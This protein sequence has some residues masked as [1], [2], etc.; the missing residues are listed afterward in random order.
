MRRTRIGAVLLVGAVGLCLGASIP[1]WL[2]DAI[3][4]WN[5]ENP[6]VS[7]RFVDI[8]DEFVWYM[9]PENE[10]F[11]QREIRARIHTI[12]QEHGY[13][14]TDEEELVTTGKPPSPVS[15]HIPKKCWRRSY[16]LDIQALSDTKSSRGGR[17]SQRQR[18]LTSMVCEDEGSW[19]L[20][21]RILQ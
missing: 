12:A 11:G 16:V 6:E 21:F 9:L 13:R 19:F 4:A 1:A 8:K 5:E 10:E 2:D 20:G 17:S 14:T 3:S 7:I 15:P 18:M